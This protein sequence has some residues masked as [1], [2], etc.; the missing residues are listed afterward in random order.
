MGIHE[1]NAGIGEHDPRARTGGVLCGGTRDGKL[2]CF[3]NS[4]PVFSGLYSLYSLLV[5]LN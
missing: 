4:R 1:W 2:G 3:W 5:S